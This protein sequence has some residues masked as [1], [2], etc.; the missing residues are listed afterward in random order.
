LCAQAAFGQDGQPTKALIG[1]AAKNGVG[2]EDV[3]READAKGVEYVFAIRKQAGRHAAEVRLSHRV[4]DDAVHNMPVS[5]AAILSKPA[6]DSGMLCCHVLSFTLFVIC[7]WL[8]E[9]HFSGSH[10]CLHGCQQR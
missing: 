5:S 4:V 8:S 9:A 7:W 10:P 1:F 6:A 2:A 3:T